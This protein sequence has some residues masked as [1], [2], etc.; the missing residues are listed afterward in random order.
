[1]DIYRTFGRIAVVSTIVLSAILLVVVKTGHPKIKLAVNAAPT[2]ASARPV[3]TPKD[4]SSSLLDTFLASQ[5]L[6]SEQETASQDVLGDSWD[7]MYEESDDVVWTN[8][9]ELD[10][11][12]QISS[13]TSNASAS[14]SFG[15]STG[16]ESTGSA[17]SSGSGGNSSSSSSAT[18]TNTSTA[19]SDSTGSAPQTA[20]GGGGGSLNR[21]LLED[22]RKLQPLPKVHYSWGLNGAF[23]VREPEVMYELARLTHALSVFGEVVQ[24]QLIDRCV[25]TC[26]RV[27][28][29][30]P[31]IPSSIAVVYSP[32]HY[33]FRPDLGLMEPIPVEYNHTIFNYH[34]YQE[35]I[36]YFVNC[37]TVF[38]QLVSQSNQTYGS[39]VKVG[40]LLLDSERFHRREYD[41][42][43]FSKNE[44]HLPLN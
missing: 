2:A 24:P 40:A 22:L 38:K 9:G 7:N 21:T 37:M 6:Q 5:K 23:M 27:N 1:M 8:A 35:E 42:Y 44:T 15:G 13:Q 19:N 41:L 18:G 16:T 4:P 17:S 29:T 10:S 33:K 30:N 3:E 31:E 39:D 25:D 32:W 26:D 12:T 20:S 14:S 36:D 34:T 43:V 28:K 11:P